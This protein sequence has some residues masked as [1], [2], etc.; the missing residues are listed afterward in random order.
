VCVCVY[1]CTY[2]VCTFS[3][4][5]VGSGTPGQDRTGQDSGQC[6][7]RVTVRGA[8]LENG[9]KGFVHWAG[10]AGLAGLDS[11]LII[12]A[13]RKRECKRKCK[14]QSAK[15]QNAGVTAHHPL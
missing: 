7:D 5:Q 4:G 11:T 13:K 6:Q 8:E 12:S 1:A 15:V 14:V 3:P 9:W 2:V 10:L